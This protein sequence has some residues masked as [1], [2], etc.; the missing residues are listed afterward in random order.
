MPKDKRPQQAKRI[1]QETFDAVVK[2]NCDEFGMEPE[3][4]IADAEEQFKSQGVDLSNIVTVPS[5]QIKVEGDDDGESCHV[6]VKQLAEVQSRMEA[7]SID[8]AA[9]LKALR[10]LSSSLSGDLAARC[11]A[12]KQGGLDVFL[13]GVERLNNQSFIDSPLFVEVLQ[14]MAVFLEGQPDIV[15]GGVLDTILAQVTPN[16]TCDIL[17]AVLKEHRGKAAIQAA[18]IRAVRMCCVMHESNRLTF[19]ANGLIEI[20]LACTDAHI[21]DASAVSEAAHCLRVLTLDDDIRVPF[22]KVCTPIIVL[23]RACTDRTD[24]HMIMRRL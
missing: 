5:I 21:G 3:E 19:I 13:N 23:V 15:C 16:R 20:L 17:C 7:E 14:T 11:L 22:G 9:H 1:T 18:G 2:E 12:A 4:A 6:V 24:R 8:E 10:E